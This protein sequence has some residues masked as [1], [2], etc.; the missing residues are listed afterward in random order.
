MELDGYLRDVSPSM[1]EVD[2]SPIYWHLMWMQ[3][4]VN[5]VSSWK[6]RLWE[7]ADGRRNGNRR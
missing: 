3:K 5:M 4:N 1:M 7:Y 6:F 2:T